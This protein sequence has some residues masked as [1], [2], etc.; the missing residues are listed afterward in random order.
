MKEVLVGRPGEDIVAPH[1]RFIAEGEIV[2]VTTTGVE[3]E[4]YLFL[5][6]D[7]LV[8]TVE[9][10]KGILN[11]TKY[12]HEKDILLKDASVSDMMDPKSKFTCIRL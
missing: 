9:K 8:T 7:M 1:R 3:K 4:R 11:S 5:F 6:N 10:K 2:E 12:H